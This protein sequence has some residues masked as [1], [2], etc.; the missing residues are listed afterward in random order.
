[1]RKAMSPED[2]VRGPA[3]WSARRR[4][5]LAC[6]LGMGLG[7]V[8]CGGVPP[9]AGAGAGPGAGP[10]AD[11]TVDLGAARA[12]VPAMTGLLNSLG[13]ATSDEVLDDLAPRFLRGDLSRLLVD[14]RF[15]TERRWR[16]ADLER[17]HARGIERIFT[18]DTTWGHPAKLDR[19]PDAV[20]PDGS[21]MWLCAWC[22]PS[23]PNGP[24]WDPTHA[25]G[26]EKWRSHVTS[27]I[28][29]LVRVV[30][31]YN[32][33]HEAAPVDIEKEF[34]FDVWNE[35]NNDVFW[36]TGKT[37]EYYETYCVAE[38][39][40]RA[41][42]PGARVAGPSFATYLAPKVQG[43]LDYC[44]GVVDPGYSPVTSCNRCRVDVLNW[45]ANL[46]DRTGEP[47]DPADPPYGFEAVAASV[48]HAHEAWI[49][50]PTYADLGIEKLY[51]FEGTGSG[52]DDF[53]RPGEAVRYLQTFED[54]GVDGAVRGC[55]NE[56]CFDQSVAGLYNGPAVVED[57]ET[58]EVQISGSWVRRPIGWVFA[59]YPAG[60]ESRVGAAS[61]DPALAVVASRSGAEPDAVQILVGRS[62]Q[63]GVPPGDPIDP[64]VAL[65]NIDA[66]PA[67]RG[68]SEV[69]AEILYL[70][71]ACPA[72]ADSMECG[73]ESLAEPERTHER[74]E[75]AG[76]RAV[77]RTRPLAIHEAMLIY[78][79]RAA[80]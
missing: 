29:E 63:T 15:D 48:S 50:N 61:T 24:P 59:T 32:A 17:I 35:P 22:S 31:A 57:P 74:A 65:E 64:V 77:L 49:D 75:V 11:I 51:F 19:F 25:G 56:E 55:W 54:S 34:I 4:R 71:Y 58:G 73:V 46:A 62:R 8:S 23:E 33:A 1:M 66:A 26:F 30:D 6:A 39:A 16:L 20:F 52:Y 72:G 10:A 69:D 42:L 68:A 78:V 79:R 60:V 21:P 37:N 38:N 76:G 13:S 53:H 18:V 28:D 36:V 45:H 40:I 12:G 7:V 3:A 2:R 47:I 44:R 67:L 14:P 27:T 70:P 80:P 5:V 43:L 9:G 41:V